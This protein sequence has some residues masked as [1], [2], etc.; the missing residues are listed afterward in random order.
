MHRLREQFGRPLVH[1]V[2]MLVKSTGQ[3]H[4]P[5]LPGLSDIEE[6]NPHANPAYERGLF[7]RP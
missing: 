5:S 7:V 6:M 1:N 4:S 2:L 3:R